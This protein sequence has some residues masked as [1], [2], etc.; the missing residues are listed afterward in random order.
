M[1]SKAAI[2]LVVLF[3]AAP[4][5]AGFFELARFVAMTAN[6]APPLPPD[7]TTVTRLSLGGL[8]QTYSWCANRLTT[9]TENLWADATVPAALTVALRSQIRWETVAFKSSFDAVPGVAC[10]RLGPAADSPSLN[11]DG[12]ADGGVFTGDPL[13]VG[14][15]DTWEV[16][17]ITTEPVAANAVIPVWVRMSTG[18][19]RVCL[20]VG[21]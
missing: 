6:T 17:P 13:S 1:K 7:A 10:V 19:G 14:A 21:L 12:G 4:L 8:G 11:C 9:S 5:W 18:T 3:F 15:S 16:R 2:G 20:T